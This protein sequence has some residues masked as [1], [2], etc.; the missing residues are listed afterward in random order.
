MILIAGPSANGIADRIAELR[1]EKAYNA[2]HKVFPDGE[3]YIKM[4]QGI[5]GEEVAIIQ[6][7]NNPQDK[8][9]MELF[10]MI[11]KARELGAKSVTAIVPYMGYMR[12]NKEFNEGE[13]VSINTIISILNSLHLDNLI[14]IQP[15]KSGPLRAF[16]G[17]T[18]IVEVIGKMAEYA[19]D[20]MHNPIVLAPDKGALEIARKA[21]ASMGC[22]YTY[23]DKERLND[24]K[25][26]IKHSPSEDMS[27]RDVMIIDDMISTGGTIVQAAEFARSRGARSVRA[28]AVHLIMAGNAE[29]KLMNAGISEIC[30]TNTLPFKGAKTFDVSGEI[31]KA[32]GGLGLE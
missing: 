9:L 5:A 11:D 22:I 30:G 19:G 26:S 24:T 16:K 10:F 8:S 2:V 23:I 15:H 7:T 6:S 29:E 17:K 31:S 18:I 21:A 27:G 1:G 3:S 13:A 32:L 25:V 12:Q 14:T 20:G 4:P 28:A